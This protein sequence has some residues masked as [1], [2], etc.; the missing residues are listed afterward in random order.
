MPYLQHP[1]RSKTNRN[2]SISTF[3]SYFQPLVNVV[4]N[5]KSIT[6]SVPTTSGQALSQVRNADGQQW[7]SYAIVLAQ[8][9]GFFTVGE[10]IG[11]LKVVGYHGEVH[12]E[13]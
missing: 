12:Q 5:P 3:Q 7:T 8:L 11:R 6:S 13:H 1:P 9:L 2:S 10:M 4:R